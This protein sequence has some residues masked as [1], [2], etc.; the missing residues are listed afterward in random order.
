[1]F[2]LERLESLIA[3]GT[4][5]P[6]TRKVLVDKD[7]IL[8][9]IDQLRVAVPEEVHAAKRINAEGERIIE[10]ANDEAGKIAARAQ[11]QAAYLI[12]EKGLTERA[13]AEGRQIVA[14]AMASADS[15][16]L[17]A[18]A[19][20]AD[21]LETLEAEVRKALAGIEKGIDVLQVRQAELAATTPAMSRRR[22]RPRKPQP[23]TWTTGRTCPRTSRHSCAKR[24]R[25]RP[26]RDD[27]AGNPALPARGPARRALR[28]RAPLRDPRRH[29][30]TARR[31]APRR[32]P[33]RGA[34]ISR[35]NR[36]VLVDATISTA[37]AGSCAR[38]LRDIELPMTV[39]IREEALPSVDF[40]TG[41]AVDLNTEPDATRLSDHH[42]LDFAALAADAISLEE[43]IVALCEEAC[44]GLCVECGQRLGPEHAEHAVDDVDPRL[45]A[46]RGFKVDGEGERVNSRPA[47]RRQSP[48]AHPE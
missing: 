48:Q 34:A 41:A 7:A 3:T 45:A 30:P 47:A 36:G 35:T 13:Q 33:R 10:K 25:A 17:G 37:I 6:T 22:S 44:P 43:P 20:A 14:E 11:E 21:I 29:H 1:M 8:E 40:A 32:A 12:G 26:S 18:D 4:G 39:R 19:Y 46:L 42:E 5:V 9:L 38:C 28:D 27:R 2:L 23:R 31:P 15:T 24:T 16:R